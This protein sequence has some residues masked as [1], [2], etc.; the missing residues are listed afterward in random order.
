MEGR[1]MT[2]SGK[3]KKELVEGGVINFFKII[4]CTTLLTSQI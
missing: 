3:S 4:G 1:S 2:V